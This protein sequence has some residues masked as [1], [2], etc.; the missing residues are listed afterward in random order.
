MWHSH[1]RFEDESDEAHFSNE[2]MNVLEEM[3]S[4][5]ESFKENHYKE[6]LLSS[7]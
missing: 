2:K 3:T 1:N 7:I 4:F 5:F 6:G